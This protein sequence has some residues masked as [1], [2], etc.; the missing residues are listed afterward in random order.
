MHHHE[1]I[2]AI[3]RTVDH[4][5]ARLERDNR[6]L[7]FGL[8]LTLLLPMAFFATATGWYLKRLETESLIV[9][10]PNGQTVA[11]IGSDDTEGSTSGDGY[12]TLYRSDGSVSLVAWP[13]SNRLIRLAGTDSQGPNGGLAV[14]WAVPSR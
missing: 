9:R 5:L 4:R 3:A 2:V 1:D 13:D 6:R 8:L 10:G 11:V 7:R 12:L 14:K